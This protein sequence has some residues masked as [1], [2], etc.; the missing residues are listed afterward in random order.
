[1]PAEQT[2]T[3]AIELH[4][5]HRSFGSVRAV[6]GIDLRLGLGEIAA[7]LG[8][9][10]AGKTTTIVLGIE[11][12]ESPERQSTM[13]LHEAL[14]LILEDHPEGLPPVDLLRE[15]IRGGLYATRSGQPPAVGQ[16]HARVGSYDHLFGRENGRILRKAS[17]TSGFDF[18]PANRGRQHAAQ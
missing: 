2:S 11:P 3:A 8:P 16:I 12:V 9:N 15:T 14:V 18:M 17:L 1:M 5:M 6:D 13:P 7:L 4:G 10:G